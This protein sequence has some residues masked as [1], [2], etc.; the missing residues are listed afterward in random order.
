MSSRPPRRPGNREHR[1][2][3]MRSPS[4]TTPRPTTLSIPKVG[5][6]VLLAA[7]L[8]TLTPRPSLAKANPGPD[9]AAGVFD[10]DK[11]RSDPS[12]AEKPKAPAVSERDAIGFTQENVAAQM[13][14]LEERM[15]R[16]SEALRG[17]EPE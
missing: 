11:T 6:L 7:S 9:K 15:F 17:L 12:A 4:A 8:V 10:D 14:E 13:T 5:G 2:F 1:R 3:S 16:L